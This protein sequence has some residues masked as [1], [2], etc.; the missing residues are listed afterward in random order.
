M[1][2]IELLIYILQ[3]L[4]LKKL[5]QLELA[6]SFFRGLV[7][8]YRWDHLVSLNKLEKI[9]YV[10][11][12]YKFKRY[13]FSRSYITDSELELLGSC[14]SINLSCCW[15]ISDTGVKFL[16]KCTYLDL[17]YC[18]KLTD[19]SIQHLGSCKFL[20]LKCCH[21]I[22]DHGVRFLNCHKLDLL[23]CYKVSIRPNCH[24]LTEPNAP[25]S[26]LPWGF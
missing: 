20:D 8:G 21:Q 25:E 7:R 6:S 10:I 15:V 19:E 13:D 2:P 18:Y 24:S 5:I 12:T 11:T 4:E 16:K 3:N 22:T 1:I 26:Y 9:Q 14:L 23:H 17:S